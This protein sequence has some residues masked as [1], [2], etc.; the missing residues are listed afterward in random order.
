[1]MDNK[2][3][4]HLLQECEH[5][6]SQFSATMLMEHVPTAL[7]HL[8][9]MHKCIPDVIVIHVGESDF[10][11]VSNKQPRCNV[12]KL[13][14]KVKK[15]LKLVD[16][17]SVRCRAVFYSHMVSLPWYMGWN[18]QRAAHRARARLNGAIA[19]C[20]QDCGAYV[21]PHLGIQAVQGEG[22]YDI[23]HPGTL[24]VMGNLIFMSNVVNKVKKIKCPFKVAWQKQQ[25]PHK[26]FEV[27]TNKSLESRI[28]AMDIHE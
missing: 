22:L 6:R 23:H 11:Q 9:N 24:L 8:L 16:T 18:K 27:V 21:I 5:V 12:E 13:T 25:L 10:S 3:H 17:H 26:M 1:M 4:F 19:K 15:L 28:A 7:I 14:A 20:T 2:N